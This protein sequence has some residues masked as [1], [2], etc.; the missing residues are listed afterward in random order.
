MFSCIKQYNTETYKPANSKS[1][2]DGILNNGEY[3]VDCGG[4]CDPCPI[5]K[6]FVS[7][8]ADSTWLPSNPGNKPV[9]SDYADVIMQGDYFYITSADT[10]GS[11]AESIGLSFAVNRNWGLGVHYADPMTGFETY[12]HRPPGSLPG[13]VKMESGVIT[14]TNVDLVNG[15]M[16]GEFKFNS[17]PDVVTGNRVTIYNGI[18][19]DIPTAAPVVP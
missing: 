15:L 19:K 7:F 14:I 11:K 18:F 16:S 1:C 12:Y 2:G 13:T 4:P 8:Q 5:G 10:F 17:A 3:Y 9:N 6:P